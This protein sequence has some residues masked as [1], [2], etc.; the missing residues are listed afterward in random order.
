MA[1]VAR[2]AI[3][4]AFGL[5]LWWFGVE[6]VGVGFGALLTE[7]VLLAT[8]IPLWRRGAVGV[9]DLGLRTV[10]GARATGL[11]IL[12]LFAYGWFSLLW[13]RA[14]HL[15]PQPT[16]NFTGVSHQSTAAIVLAGF[17]ACVGAPVAE[18]IFFRGFLYR[19]LRNRFTILGACL[20]SSIL[21]GLDHTQY[22]LVVR[23]EIVFFGVITC[24]LYERTGSL[25]PGIALHSF[26]DGSGFE[27]ALTGNASVVGWTYLLLAAILLARPPLKGLWRLLTGR[28]IFR[29]YFPAE[30]ASQTCEP[31][32][33]Q[34]TPLASDPADAFGAPERQRRPVWFAGTLC[35][36]PLLLLLAFLF[37][38]SVQLRVYIGAQYR[39]IGTQY[40]PCTAAGIDSAEGHEGICVE[41]PV[42]S[43]TTVNVVDRARTLHMPEYDVRLLESQIMP[44]HVTNA[45]K[46]PGLYPH[47]DGQLVSYELSLTN[48]TERPEQFGIGTDHRPRPFY[49][50]NPDIELELPETPESTNYFVATY[51]PIIQGRRA[52][53]PSI[54]QQPFIAP[55]ETRNGW[56]SFVAPAWTLSVWNKPPEDLN[57]F[58]L[59]GDRR[60]RGA[61]RL[62]K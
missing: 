57:F 56:V 13:A 27:R 25:L 59:D 11:A 31:P 41:G 39:S 30:D 16:S 5:V 26:I 45:F 3:L 29:E 49:S 20:V 42:A 47:G 43:R 48:T 60:Y 35:A 32:M 51:P 6:S 21:F 8:L 37:R 52:P 62:W 53:T 7:A 22:P 34:D 1:Y 50:P 18:E 44:T 55:H 19:S 23:P 54:L 28:P 33:Q 36:L 46:H 61:I 10:P 24:L 14:L 17:A 2:W 4:I 9:K 58:K 12:G 40:R 15:T 38:P